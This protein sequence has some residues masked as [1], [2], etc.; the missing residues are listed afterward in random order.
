[1]KGPTGKLPLLAAALAKTS[2]LEA[3]YL[4]KILT[5]D[6]RIGLKEGLVE[7]A[8][9]QA[10]NVS[11]DQIKNA[12]LLLGHIGETATLARAGQLD[13]VTLIPFRPVKYML[14]S[15]EPT[16][17]DI[18]QRVLEWHDGGKARA[19]GAN[20]GLKLPAATP[21]VWIEDK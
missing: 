11:L 21:S 13:A 16:A 18:W 10:F 5:G 15:P 19:E 14:A 4:V 8:I 7:D 1:A 9:A 6:L 2:P 3:K 20:L 17:A 12:N